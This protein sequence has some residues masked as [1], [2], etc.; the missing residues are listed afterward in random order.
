M[1]ILTLLRRWL[2]AGVVNEDK[3]E[4]TEKGTPQGGSISV[5]ISN[6]YLHFV[7]D[8][9][10]EKVVKPRMKGRVYYVRYLDDFVLCFE[11]RV[12]AQKF[13]DALVKRLEKFSLELEPSKTKLMS[14]GRGAAIR[15][16][17]SNKKSKT[18]EFL[19][20]TFFADKT[21]NGKYKVG[22]R[23]AKCRLR[24]S[25][26]KMSEKLRR[27]RHLALK[28]QQRL[29]K[30]ILLG[31]YNYYGIAGNFR[32]LS[33][34]YSFIRRSWFRSLSHRSQSGRLNWEKYAQILQFF[35]IPKPRI[36]LP[37]AEL[38]KLAML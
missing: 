16:V 8:L 26:L 2:K 15:S 36:I 19:G 38:S 25:M 4:P 17:S 13:E 21:R 23:T 3:L 29:I 20:F 14:F 22:M 30:H 6:I 9:W 5:L 24:R 10:I 12:D 1:R 37:Y 34:A 33:K 27:A 11:F 32:Q 31:H 18:F 7:L 28:V 35:P